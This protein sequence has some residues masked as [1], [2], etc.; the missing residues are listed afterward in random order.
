MCCL[1]FSLSGMVERALALAHQRFLSLAN[2]FTCRPNSQIVSCEAVIAQFGEGYTENLNQ[3]YK[4][5]FN[6]EGL[7]C[8]PN[9]L[10]EQEYYCMYAFNP[11]DYIYQ[12]CV[13]R[14]VFS[15]VRF[16]LTHTV[17]SICTCLLTDDTVVMTVITHLCR[18]PV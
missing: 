4:G 17:T 2:N 3:L 14:D 1:M 7:L 11:I 8:N 10:A 5:G 15:H 13:L 16:S 9:K 18:I 12:H 6:L